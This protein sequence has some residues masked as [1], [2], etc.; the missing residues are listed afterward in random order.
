MEEET[1]GFVT[2]GMERKESRGRWRPEL[3]IL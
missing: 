2:Q 1:N 3:R